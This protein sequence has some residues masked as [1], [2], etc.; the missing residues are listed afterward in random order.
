M[1][2]FYV[3]AGDLLPPLT[4][5]LQSID[6]SSVDLTGTTVTRELTEMATGNV[7]TLPA[8][9]VSDPTL[10]QVAHQWASGETA[11]SGAYF[12]HWLVTW[13]GPSRPE[14]FPNDSRGL[15]LVVTP[16]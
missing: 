10:G 16:G 3:R 15:V 7:T 8:T 11:I 9:I 14:S 12:Y 6:S 13:P 2:S 1:A 4:G 5:V